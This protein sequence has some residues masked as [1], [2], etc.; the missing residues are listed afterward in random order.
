MQQQE[1]EVICNENDKEITRKDMIQ[2]TLDYFLNDSGNIGCIDKGEE[3]P[4]V[5]GYFEGS[6]G[7][8]LATYY[9]IKSV[10]NKGLV[11]KTDFIDPSDQKEW[12]ESP[13]AYWKGPLK[14]GQYPSI[15]VYLNGT[16]HIFFLYIF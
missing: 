1:I 2:D 11:T 3:I 14:P 10:L 7:R 8:E 6:Y 4:T 13:C 12:E 5:G 15:N 16:K 9:F